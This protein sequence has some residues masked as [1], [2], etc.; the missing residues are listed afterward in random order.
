[1]GVHSS[2]GVAGAGAY[3][4]GL[5]FLGAGG[6]FVTEGFLTNNLLAGELSVDLGLGL[7]EVL[8]GRRTARERLRASQLEQE[9]GTLIRRRRLRERAPEVGRGAVGKRPARG[10]SERPASASR[11]PTRRRGRVWQGGGRP[12]ARLARPAPRAV[13]R[14]ARAGS[15]APRAARHGR[16][17]RPP[18]DERTPAAAQPAGSP[19]AGARPRRGP[20]SFRQGRRAS[21]RRR[22]PRRRRARRLPAPC[23]L[24][25]GGDVRAAIERRAIPHADPDRRPPP[26]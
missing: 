10:P 22:A 21:R 16:R 9:L 26:T 20:H 23:S 18:A 14:P 7:P 11:R 4:L 8:S 15:P 25:P 3:L 6:G 5:L 1:M 19:P 12:P 2:V 24:R 13:S 17:R